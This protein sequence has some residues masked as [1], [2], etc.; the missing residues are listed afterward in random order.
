MTIKRT[1][2][3]WY[4]VPQDTKFLMLEWDQCE[5]LREAR[6]RFQR[7]SCIYVFVEPEERLVN[8]VGKTVPGLY[9]RYPRPSQWS[10][11]KLVFVAPLESHLLRYIEHALIYHHRPQLNLRG[12]GTRPCPHIPILHR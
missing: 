9:S 11:D 4:D 2:H 7:T 8:Y 10:R 5:S 1:L 3:R 6:Y 12:F